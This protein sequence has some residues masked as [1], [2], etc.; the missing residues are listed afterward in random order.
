ML[1]EIDG[2]NINYEIS[3]TEGRPWLTF[4]NS[5]A[6]DLGMWNEQAAALAGEF[7]ILRYDKRGHGG[8]QPVEGPYSFDDLIGDIVG[9]LGS[10][11]RRTILLRR[12]VHRR[13]DGAGI[14]AEAR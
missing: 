8:S 2:V 4:S 13:D 11:G 3:G 5:L 10:S 6:A 12:A 1:A 9:L 14:V 7:R